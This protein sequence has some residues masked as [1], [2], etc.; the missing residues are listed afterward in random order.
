MTED[1]QLAG[2]SQVEGGPCQSLVGLQVLL[3]V[4]LPPEGFV[5][6]GYVA[7]EGLD[8]GVDP[9]VTGQ[10]L[11]PSKGLP[12]ARE[13]AFKRPLAWNRN[14]VLT[15]SELMSVFRT[16]Q[17]CPSKSWPSIIQQEFSDRRIGV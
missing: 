8:P 11:V 1:S 2:E 9:L 5:T 6:A 3:Q 14:F 4:V 10:L 13:G 7:G 16:V 17:I 12:T 15:R